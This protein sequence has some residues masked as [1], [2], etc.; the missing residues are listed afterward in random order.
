[1]SLDTSRYCTFSNL[2]FGIFIVLC[3]QAL[4]QLLSLCGPPRQKL[5]CS[6]KPTNN[7]KGN[8]L[9]EIQFRKVY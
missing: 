3:L 4:L 9:K 5:E 8:I 2:C 7:Y 1:M 6:I